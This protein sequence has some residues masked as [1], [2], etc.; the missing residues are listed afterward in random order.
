MILKMTK[1]IA[2]M[3]VDEIQFFHIIS[4]V[5]EGNISIV[6]QFLFVRALAVINHLIK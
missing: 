1:R 3:A 2:Q 5:A 4:D 6:Q